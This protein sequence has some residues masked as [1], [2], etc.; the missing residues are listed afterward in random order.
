MWANQELTNGTTYYTCAKQP[1]TGTLTNSMENTLSVQFSNLLLTYSYCEI[2]NFIS[3]ILVQVI[4]L[5]ISI[6]H[7]L[8]KIKLL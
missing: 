3:C 6:F 1:N 2:Q 4:L 5:K 8:T 7:L